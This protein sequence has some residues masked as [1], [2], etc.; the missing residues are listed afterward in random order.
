MRVLVTGGAGLLG[1]W[2]LR[3]APPAWELYATQRHSPVSGAPAHTVELSRAR[4]VLALWERLR[5]GLV[6]HTAYS[7]GEAR[8][9]TWKATHSVVDACEAVGAALIHLSTDALFDG[10]H[11][12]Y[13]ESAEPAPVHEY[14]EWKARAELHVRERMPGA[15]VVRTSLITEFAPLDPRSAWVAE[16]LRERKPLS[17]FVDELRCPITA[18]DLARQLWEIAALPFSTR[19]GVWH[20]AGPEALS[21]YALGTLIAA[22]ERLD[23]AGIT[24]ARSADAPGRRPR[25]ARLLTTRAD[26]A[27][28]T[29]ARPISTLLLPSSLKES[30]E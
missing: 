15:A 27:L 16:A 23:A 13:D 4:D 28:Q 9:D 2:L 11:G 29:R 30:T 7:A 12:P 21:R 20:L 6:I 1:S 3:T 17:L 19:A 10:E 8:R 18:L 14:G 25:D 22:H 26:A 5:P 24:P